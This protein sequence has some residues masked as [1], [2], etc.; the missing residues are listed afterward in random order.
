[1]TEQE[2]KVGTV[3]EHKDKTTKGIY[4]HDGIYV[5]VSVKGR[6]K[7]DGTWVDSISYMSFKDYEEEQVGNELFGYVAAG[8]NRDGLALRAAGYLME[9]SKKAKRILL[10]LTDANPMDDQNIG[11]GA[12]YTNKEYTDQPAIE[13]TAREVQRLKQK[14]I[15]VIG[16]FMGSAKSREAA[17]E[18]FDRE[19][20]QIQNINDFAGAVGRVLGEVMTP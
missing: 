20:V 15:Q 2:L 6:M 4:P 5:V 19:L 12:F 18:I 14:G 13:D 11:E 3:I 17:R 9:A 8:N 10:V 1:M 16:I 7:M